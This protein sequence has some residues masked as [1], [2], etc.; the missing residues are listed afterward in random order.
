MSDITE[1]RNLQQQFLQAQKMETIG[2]L[3]GGIAHDFNNILTAINLTA[4]LAQ[5][6]LDPADPNFE[7]FSE[8]KKSGDRAAALTRQLLAFSR[9][10][11]IEPKAVNINDILLDMDKMLR[12]LVGEHI[13]YVTVPEEKLLSAMIDPDQVEQVLTNLVV[14]ARDAMPQGGK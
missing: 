1:Y 4:E 2:R 14:N 3:A 11:I 7:A 8:V 9:R 6:F 10:Q 5:M 13:E 12:R